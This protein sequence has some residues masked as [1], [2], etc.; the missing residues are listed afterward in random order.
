[1]VQIIVLAMIFLFVGLRLWSVLGR[2]TGHEQPIAK[3]VEAEAVRPAPSLRVPSPETPPQPVTAEPAI[4]SHAA[5]GI[6]AIVAA[7]SDFD[8]TR[9]LGG[10]QSAYRMI[11]EAFWKGDEEELGR[12]AGDD[13]RDAFA[14]AIA[15]RDAEGHVLENR[16]VAIERAVIERARLDRQMAYVTVRFDADIAAV[17]RDREGNVIAG[18][19]SDAVPTHDVWTFS[20]HVRA[21]DP[22][23]ILIETDE[24]A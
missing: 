22:N 8:V 2:R 24:A 18:S 19:M 14:A 15:E 10:A 11:L 4:D 13:V 21:D 12:L 23:W 20:R 6:R 5:E 7:D 3:P 16:L 17:T 9:F 1:V